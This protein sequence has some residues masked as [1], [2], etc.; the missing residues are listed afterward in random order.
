METL[1][2]VDE[3]NWPNTQQGDVNEDYWRLSL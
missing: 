3:G 1:Q 2:E